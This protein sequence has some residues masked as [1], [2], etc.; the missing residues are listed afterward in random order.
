[1][2]AITHRLYHTVEAVRKGSELLAHRV[3]SFSLAEKVLLA[4]VAIV[5]LLKTFHLTQVYG[6]RIC[7]KHHYFP[8]LSDCVVAV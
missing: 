5:S 4:F 8:A 2:A 1:M 3:V 7:V 6:L